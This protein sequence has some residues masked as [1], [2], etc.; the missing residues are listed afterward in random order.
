MAFTGTVSAGTTPRPRSSEQLLELLF[1]E[2][3]PHPLERGPGPVPHPAKG[4]ANELVGRGLALAVV[5]V[6]EPDVEIEPTRDA[7]HPAGLEAIV[8]PQGQLADET[9][10]E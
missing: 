5:V 2:G 6:G 10:V 7:V 3:E 4:C 1:V 8:R 9:V